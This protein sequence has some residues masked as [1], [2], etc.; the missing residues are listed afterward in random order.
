MDIRLPTVSSSLKTKKALNS[1]SEQDSSLH[2]Q[3]GNCMSIQD[4]GPI[5]VEDNYLEGIAHYLATRDHRVN[6]FMILILTDILNFFSSPQTG[7]LS[8][9]INKLLIQ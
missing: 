3:Q 9:V 1:G 6:S 8:F 5:E 4:I 7:I 2:Q